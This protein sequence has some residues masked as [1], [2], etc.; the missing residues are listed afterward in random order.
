MGKD[1]PFSLRA[2][3]SQRWQRKHIV[4]FDTLIKES[5]SEEV[6]AVLGQRLFISLHS[7]LIPLSQHTNLDIGTSSTQPSFS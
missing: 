3:G 5:K 6:E 7:P 2:F 1:L 4:I